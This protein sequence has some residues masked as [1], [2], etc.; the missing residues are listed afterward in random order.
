[1][2]YNINNTSQVNVMIFLPDDISR[3][4]VKQ[5]IIT[6]VALVLLVCHILP[7]E[8]ACCSTPV[9]LELG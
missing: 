4:L 3:R 1:M 5:A 9:I 8:V 2:M 7:F 6:G